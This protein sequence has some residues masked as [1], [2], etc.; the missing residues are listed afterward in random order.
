MHG[1]SLLLLVSRS[2][3]HDCCSVALQG[4]ATWL[5]AGPSG[6]LVALSI[7][8][9]RVR[10]RFVRAFLLSCRPGTTFS[11]KGCNL[12][13]PAELCGWCRGYLYLC[14][15]ELVRIHVTGCSTALRRLLPLRFWV[16]PVFRLCSF[17]RYCWRSCPSPSRVCRSVKRE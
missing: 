3:W 13:R 11:R 17:G 6:R 9:C 12:V 10:C 1:F 4:V 16:Q 8:R 7:R 15:L 5:C 14:R 2:S